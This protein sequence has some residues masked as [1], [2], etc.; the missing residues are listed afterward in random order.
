[1][2]DELD[3]EILIDCRGADT[4]KFTAVFDAPFSA[5]D[6]LAGLKVI[7]LLLGVTT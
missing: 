4:V 1:M 6:W 5:T 7:P 3:A 2:I